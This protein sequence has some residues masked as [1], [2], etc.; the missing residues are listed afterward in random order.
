MNAVDLDESALWEAL[1]SGADARG[2][3]RLIELHL[4]FARIMAGKLFAGA[5][6]TSSSS[7]TTCSSRPWR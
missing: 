3:R 5:P 4:P 7:A 1:R 6:T 2:A